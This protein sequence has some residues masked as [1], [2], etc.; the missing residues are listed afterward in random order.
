MLRPRPARWFEALCPR[1]ASARIVGVLARTGEVEVEVRSDHQAELRLQEL[2]EG[3]ES[4]RALIPHYS[5]Y[6]ARGTLDR[7]SVGEPPRLIMKRALE[8]LEKWRR[9]ADPL[10]RHLQGLEEERNRLQQCARV[11]QA[12]GDSTMD[13]TPF[14]EIG[15]I[16]RRL[17]ALLPKHADLPFIGPATLYLCVPLAAETYL[18]AV[19]PASELATTEEHIKGLG[20]RLLQPPQWL[21]GRPAAAHRQILTHLNQIERDI[22]RQTQRLDALYGTH[23]LP[24][25]LGDLTCLEWFTSKVGVLELASE[26]F[27]LVTGWTSDR[28]GEHLV[29][30]LEDEGIPAL[31]RFPEPPPGATPPQLLDNP[32]WARPF[33]VFVRAMGV[34][35]GTEADP[36]PVLAVVVPLLFGY[37]FGDLGQGAVLVLAGWWLRRRFALARLL[38]SAGVSAAVFGLVF[39]SVFSMEHLVPAL[40]LHPLE[41]PVTVLLIPLA[42]GVVLLGAGQMLDCLAAAWRGELRKWLCKD[43]G[44][45][46]LYLGGIATVFEPGLYWVPLIGLAWFLTGAAWTEGPLQALGA[47]GESLERGLQILVNTLSFARVG[48]FA[49]AHAGLSSALVALAAAAETGVAAFLILAI[50]NVVVILLEGLVVSIQT[51]R[52][53]LFEF[54]ARFLRGSGRVFH[55]LPPPPTI[56]QGE[57]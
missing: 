40:W 23:S 7:T 5:R 55:P 12:M 24:Q 53:V 25:A 51:T 50:G 47:L 45:L 20:G 4:Y 52:L 37:M 38:M 9:Q 18:L 1:A 57:N 8:Q 22:A 16:L 35:G 49:L 31:I 11:F 19:G 46:V 17:A 48:A 3:L 33:E 10:I 15:P 32:P 13:F 2:A 42:M 54:F 44:F 14:G 6:W 56:V 21:R 26:H 41:H 34:P 36:S 27:A 39:G 43:A 29:Q 30:A 28:T